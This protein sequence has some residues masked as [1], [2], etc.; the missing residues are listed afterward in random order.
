MNPSLEHARALDAADPLAAWHD[1]FVLPR[2]AATGRDLVYLC[3]HSLGAQPVLAAEYVEEVMRDWRSL[4]V[5]GHFTGRHPWMTYHQ[6]LAPALAELVGAEPLEVVAMNSLTVNLHLM[7]ASF[8]RPVGERRAILLERSAFPSDRH[9]VES[10]VRHHGL[11]PAQRTD[12]DRTAPWRGLP[13]YRRPRRDDR[14]RG[15]A[16]RHGAAAG[17]S[18]T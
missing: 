4:A 3:G 9:A 1:R 14:T 8:Y 12:R 11:D 10:Q 2:D 13:A 6:R 18:S 16:H 17:R 7:L 15:R 5:E